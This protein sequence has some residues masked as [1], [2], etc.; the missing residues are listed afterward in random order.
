[1]DYDEQALFDGLMEEVSKNTIYAKLGRETFTKISYV[2]YEKLFAIA[3]SMF[4]SL[5]NRFVIIFNLIIKSLSF[6]R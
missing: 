1:M 5:C 3:P 6:I 2:F 4:F